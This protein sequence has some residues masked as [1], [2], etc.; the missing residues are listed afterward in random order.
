M[1]DTLEV[2]ESALEQAKRQYFR[3]ILVVGEAGSGKTGFLQQ[4]SKLHD[5]EVTNLT[6]ELSKR[7]LDLTRSQRSRQAE[8]LLKEIIEGVKGDPI[9]LDNTELLFDVGLELE[10]LRLLQLCSRNRV[11]V[12]SWNGLYSNGSLSYAEPS[13]QEFV[14]LK[15]IESIV[16]Q[17]N[18]TAVK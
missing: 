7:L 8:K 15:N 9:F 2:L 13:H 11:V 6:L 1:K 14:Q 17:L 18:A 12:A 16:I 5:C 4:A 10:P 3:L